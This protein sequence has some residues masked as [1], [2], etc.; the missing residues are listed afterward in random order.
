M[1][2]IDQ[3]CS[4]RP[5]ANAKYIVERPGYTPD[6]SRYGYMRIA[7]GATIIPAKL[8][9]TPRMTIMSPAELEAAAYAFHE[10]LAAFPNVGADDQ[11]RWGYINMKGEVVFEPVFMWARPFSPGGVAHVTMR[12][13]EGPF[14]GRLG[15]TLRTDGWTLYRPGRFTWGYRSPC[16]RDDRS[17]SPAHFP[18]LL[19][20][21]REGKVALMKPDGSFVFAPVDSYIHP[22]NPREISSGYI[23]SREKGTAYEC[24]RLSADGTKMSDPICCS[25]EQ[26][27]AIK[28]YPDEPF[29]PEACAAK[30]AE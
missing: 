16:G 5:H 27:C 12:D 17:R 23:L 15:T 24:R 3:P 1:P 4:H 19:S 22:E 18:L 13:P 6:P 7:D 30:A 2:F 29:D 20:D 8:R 14:T 9:V 25:R 11:V 21:H 10:G 26:A 28:P